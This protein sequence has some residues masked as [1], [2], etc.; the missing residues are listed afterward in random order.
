MLNYFNH[1]CKLKNIKK[2]ISLVLLFISSITKYFLKAH[3]I[4]ETIQTGVH[5]YSVLRS[6]VAFVW[7]KVLFGIF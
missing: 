7:S 3:V 2:S 4:L 5:L 6:R 1:Y